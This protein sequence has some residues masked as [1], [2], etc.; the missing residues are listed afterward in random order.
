[1][2]TLNWIGKDKVVNHHLDVPYLTLDRQYSPDFIFKTLKGNI[3]IVET[4]GDDRDNSDSAKK[5]KMGNALA[6]HSNIK[7]FMVF[8]HKKMDGA[9]KLDEFL[10]MFKNM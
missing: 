4:K 3:V 9:Y 1:M 6:S 10:N 5:V 8:D 2:P 7:Y